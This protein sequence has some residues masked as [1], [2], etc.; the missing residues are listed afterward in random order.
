DPPPPAEP[1]S[2]DQAREL[3]A[4]GIELGG[5]TVHHPILS[6]LP[7]GHQE[8]E[9]RGGL[10]RMAAE[11]GRAPETFAMPN[12]GAADYDAETLEALRSCGIK[13]ACTTRRGA[14]APGCELLELR[15]L[16]VGSDPISMLDARLAGLFDEAVRRFIPGR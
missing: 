5:H 9:I 14:N 6:T 2:W 13:A 7:D 11:L 1:M 12:G 16:G 10:E 3:Q 8:A 4:A 15:R